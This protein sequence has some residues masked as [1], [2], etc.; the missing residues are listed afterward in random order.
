MS[1]PSA[2]ERGA[3]NIALISNLYPPYVVG[4]YEILASYVV[5][6]LRERG[7][8]VHVLSGRGVDFPQDGMTHQVLD[9]DLDRKADYFLGGLPLTARRVF[10]WHLYNARTRNQVQKA[11]TELKPDLVVA[12]NLY[13]ASAGPLV[14]ARAVGVPLVACTADKWLLYSLDDVGK[15]VPANNRAQRLYLDMLA[16]WVQ[17][18][19]KRRGHPDYILAVSEFIRALHTE[20]GYASAQSLATYIGIRTDLFAFHPHA[21]P[22]ERPWRLIYAGQLWAGKGPQVAIEAVKL[23]RDRTGLP[24]VELD[25]YGSGTDHF[26]A[27]LNGL[28]EQH[29]LGDCVHLRGFTAQP[30]LARAFQEHDLYLFCSIWDEPFSLGLLEGMA[31]GCPTI[32]TTAGGTPEAIVAEQT[33]LLVAPDDAQQ[34]AD[35]IERLMHDRDLYLRMGNQA[36]EHVRAHWSVGAYVDHLEEIFD[37]IAR[38]HRSGDPIDLA[39]FHD[40]T[41]KTP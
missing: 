40:P 23:L 14:A 20:R 35:A 30:E 8:T 32:A 27:H 31:T 1:A 16:T 18:W 28:V 38:G 19:L 25:I 4:G 21:F 29:D 39:P 17:P 36:A 11:L 33:G 13:M 5:E 6:G 9:L 26:L 34:L 3:L 2:A 15:I 7:H 10:E 22:G 37:A 41:L 24:P 12:F